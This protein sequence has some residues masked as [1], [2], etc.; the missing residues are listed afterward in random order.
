MDP[1]TNVITNRRSIR[2][3]SD[4]DIEANDLAL[5]LQ[6]GLM[7]PSSMNTRPWHFVIVENKEQLEQLS[8][9]KSVGAQPIANAKIAVV[10]AADATKSEMWIEDASIAAAYMQLQAESLGIG[11]CWIQVR[12]RLTAD[13]QLSEDYVQQLLGIPETVSVECILALGHKGETKEPH[14]MEELLWER[15]HIN[16]WKE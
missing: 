16:S 7:A 3:Y 4:V 10:V 12:G 13:D 9:C 5:I 11:S 14:S 2:K 8:Q 6:A 1:V 15:V